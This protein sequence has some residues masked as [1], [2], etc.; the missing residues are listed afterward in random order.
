MVK[1][2]VITGAARVIG[3]QL[4]L[5]LL[6]DGHEVVLIDDLSFGYEARDVIGWQASTTWEEG[7][8][9]TVRYTSS[10]L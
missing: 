8:A 3:S 5:R 7:I 9:E 6:R 4:A 10:M 1:K 2:V